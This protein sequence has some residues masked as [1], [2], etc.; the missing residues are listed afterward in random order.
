MLLS[1]SKNVTI[2]CEVKTFCS[3]LLKIWTRSCKVSTT[4]HLLIWIYLPPKAVTLVTA[5]L[6]NTL[7]RKKEQN[8]KL[9][10]VTCVYATGI[11]REV[12]TFY[13]NEDS[14]SLSCYWKWKCWDMLSTSNLS[15][16][17]THDSVDSSKMKLFRK[18]A[19]NKVVI[20]KKHNF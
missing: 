3:L 8:W 7:H 17:D 4:N 13:D 9:W 14:F 1:G 18:Q 2:S 6:R 10:K 16:D 20:R 15:V 11:F 5:I 12:K 19:N